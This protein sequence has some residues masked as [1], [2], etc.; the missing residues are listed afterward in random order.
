M[1]LPETSGTEVDHLF[2]QP[3]DAESSFK[4]VEVDDRT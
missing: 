1:R 3:H 2:S 4:A